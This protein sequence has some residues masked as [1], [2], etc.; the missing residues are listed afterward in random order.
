MD[1]LCFLNPNHEAF[2]PSL[3]EDFFLTAL[4][5]LANQEGA[6]QGIAALSRASYQYLEFDPTGPRL[7]LSELNARLN[8]ALTLHRF[9]CTPPERRIPITGI[10]SLRELC[11]QM[12]ESLKNKVLIENA[13]LTARDTF[14]EAWRI[15]VDQDAPLKRRIGA[16]ALKKIAADLSEN[17][18]AMLLIG[19]HV[20]LVTEISTYFDEGHNTSILKAYDPNR[21]DRQRHYSYR[22]DSEFNA[23]E[24][25]IGRAAPPLAV[26]D[27]QAN[28][29]FCS[30][31]EAQLQF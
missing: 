14:Q 5:L 4:R 12:P 29:A 21:N 2:H 18:P 20:V 17:H 27:P 11:S 30:L 6:C 7:T 1:M 13:Y 16:H 31:M 3:G 25:Y 15:F 8:A 26:V 9:G 19:R 10:G 22:L 28:A 24:E 23:I